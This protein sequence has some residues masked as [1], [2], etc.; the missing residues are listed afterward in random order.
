MLQ[1]QWLT[2]NMV[3]IELQWKKGRGL[4]LGTVIDYED[5]DLDL[6]SRLESRARLFQACILVQRAGLPAAP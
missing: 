4:D 2:Y 3:P 5:L 6:D 1:H